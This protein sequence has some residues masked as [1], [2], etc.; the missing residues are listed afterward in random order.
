MLCS[1]RISPQS[2][3]GQSLA[4]FWKLPTGSISSFRGLCKMFIGHYICHCKLKI[5][6]ANLF[7]MKQA[8]G[9][10]LKD[11]LTRFSTRMTK[12]DDCDPKTTAMA[13]H[14]RLLVSRS[15]YESLVRKPPVDMTNVLS[16]ADGY[17]RL[18][19]DVALTSWKTTTA[20]I[21]T[22]A[23]KGGSSNCFLVW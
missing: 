9:E 17:I 8:E 1:T 12:V 6:I 18:E 22:T 21:I 20:V 5:E 11:Y 14:S 15:F 19:V 7:G 23:P 3:G 13:F 10:Q 4:W 2:L 16:T